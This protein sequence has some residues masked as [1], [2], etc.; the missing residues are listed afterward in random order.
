MERESLNTMKVF[1]SPLMPFLLLLLLP[2]GI[3]SS[4]C[5]KDCTCNPSTS[6][7]CYQRNS[8]TLPSGLDTSTRNL[9]LFSNGIEG[10]KSE[11]FDGLVNLEMLDLSQN[12]LTHLPDRVFETLTSLKNLDLSSNQ[13]TQISEKSFHGV[14][15][16]QR[17]YLQSNSIK[18]IHPATFTGLENLLELKLQ[19]PTDLQTPNLEALLLAGVGLTGL[20]ME[21]MLSLKNLHYLDISGNELKSFPVALKETPRL[22]HLNLAGNPMRTLKPEDLQNLNELIELD[23]SSLSLHSLPEELPQLLPNLK[24]LTVAE[25]PFNCLCNLAWLPGWLSTQGITLVRTEET[26]CHF[27]PISAG[28]VLP[29]LEHRDFGCPTTTTITTSTTKITTTTL[30]V[31]I[32]TMPTTTTAIQVPIDSDELP[33]P[34]LPA[35]PSSS[36]TDPEKELPFCPPDS[37]LNGGTCHLDQQGYITCACPY[38][39]TGLTCEIQPKSKSSLPE[40][41]SSRA[42][43]I[44]DAPELSSSQATPTSILLD[45]HLYIEKRPYI[46]GIRLTYSNLSGPDRRP[47]QLNLPASFPEYRLRGLNP[48]STYSICASPLG[49]STGSESICIEA[50]TSP[51]H[52]ARKPQVDSP[53]FTMLVPAAAIVLALVLIAVVV[54]VI[55]YR[56]RKKAKGNLDLDCEPSQLEQDGVKSG[57]DNGALPHKQLQLVMPE[58]AVQNGSLEY[59]VLLL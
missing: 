30:P 11:D 35:T 32:T 22:L 6:I 48:N 9:Y 24:K 37:C 1:L 39:I 18:A 36:S 40:P 46:R 53:R 23:I 47:N 58:P 16:L 13:I 33:L 42:T 21:L 57:L 44:A 26:R 10:I 41:E 5:P 2:D 29:R 17:L 45:L 12:K 4:D 19:G 7:F 54:G 56:R 8:P 50:H 55:C 51:Q 28:K 15:Q 25:N 34:P 52:P 59:E 20:N 14:T 3:F 27:P 31:A 38:D 43:S 49:D